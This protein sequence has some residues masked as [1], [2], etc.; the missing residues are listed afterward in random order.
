MNAE[1]VPALWNKA[2]TYARQGQWAAALAQ[3]DNV[4][5]KDPAHAMAML[6]ASR[7]ALS[8]GRYRDGLDYALRALARRPGGEEA[9]LTLARALRMYNEPGALLECVEHSRWRERRSATWL[10][11]LAMMVSTIGANELAMQMLDQAIIREPGNPQ[12]RYFRGVVQMFFGNMDEAEQELERCIAKAPGFTQAHWV[13]SRLRKQTEDAN[14]VERMRALI[15]RIPRGSDNDAYLAFALHNELHDLGRHADSWQ[16]LQQ[17]CRCKRQLTPHDRADARRMFDGLMALCDEEFVRP[18]E[19]PEPTFVPVFIVGMH[20]SG[21]TLLEQ[22]LGGHSMVADGGETYSFTTQMRYATDY[23]N[24]GVVDAEL[25]R[26][27]ATADFGLVGRR[28]YE[29]TAWRAKGQAYLTE[30]LPSNFLNLGFIAKALPQA[31]ILHMVRDPLDT[32]FSNLRTMFSDVNTFSYDQEELVE[33]YGQYR[34]LM[35]HWHTVMPGRIMDVHY[36][37]LVADPEGVMRQVMEFCGLPW[38][39]SATT[40]DGAGAVATASSPQMRG[41]II[42][43]RKA[44]WAPYEAQLRPLI[45]G[46]APFR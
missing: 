27:A 29:M 2:E 17:G 1:T 31:R 11:D 39:L 42:K 3:Y 46:L 18:V 30:K 12:A 35:A 6:R 14:H 19:Q 10:T 36:D 22:L 5:A 33:W 43:N 28:F 25:V 23:R 21:S 38:E 9:V 32:C 37:A 7:M 13:L 45:E 4:L 41:G 15:P 8:L 40:L 26:R 20:R 16:A 24:K 44:A 34:Q